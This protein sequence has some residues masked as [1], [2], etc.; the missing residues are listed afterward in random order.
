[1]KSIGDVVPPI[2][3]SSGE[4]ARVLNQRCYPHNAKSV[5]EQLPIFVGRTVHPGR[6][7]G[8]SLPNWLNILAAL[9]GNKEEVRVKSTPTSTPYYPGGQQTVA[10][11][12]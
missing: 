6:I 5:F 1:M 10:F 4:V 3:Y 12:V 7:T 9:P 8:G 2:A 11:S